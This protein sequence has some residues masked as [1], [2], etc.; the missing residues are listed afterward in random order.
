[1]NGLALKELSRAIAVVA[2]D[3]QHRKGTGEPY[4]NHVE[5][6]AAGVQGWRAKTIAYLHD[7]LEDTPI[8][9][10]G[11]RSLGFPNDIVEAVEGLTRREDEHGKESY[12]AFIERSAAHGDPDVQRVKLADIRDNLRDIDDVPGGGPSLRKRYVTA[13]ARLLESLYG[14][15]DEEK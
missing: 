9:A 3:G 11:L 7:L 14:S 6:V 8:T 1:M 2:H 5:R 10:D 12:R 4:F 13:E 15:I